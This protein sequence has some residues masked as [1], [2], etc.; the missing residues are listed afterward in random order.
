MW[1]L[2]GDAWASLADVTKRM[3]DALTLE[4]QRPPL[5]DEVSELVRLLEP[6][7]SY[8]AFPAAATWNR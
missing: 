2:R 8:W 6:L 5:R 4:D 7:E 3:S 1:R